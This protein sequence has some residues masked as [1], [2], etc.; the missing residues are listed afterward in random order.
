M[1]TSSDILSLFNTAKESYT[2]IVGLQTDNDM[3][4]LCKAIIT[5]L[6]SIS[7]GTNS[8][9]PLRLILIN[10]SYKRSLGT[11]VGFNCTIGAYKLYNP[12]IK[13][14][15][16]DGLRKRMEQEWT[17]R[18]STQSLILSYKMGFW[19]FILKV[20]EDTWVRRL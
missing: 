4:R 19:S 20:V 13:D 17:S 8:D 16:T 7:L 6:Y 15:A 12:S 10:T 14:D 11:T 2:P 18:L 9:C 3:V 1:S 5:I